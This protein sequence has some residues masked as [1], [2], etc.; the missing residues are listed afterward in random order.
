MLKI[1]EI[2]TIKPTAEVNLLSEL[3]KTLILLSGVAL[4]S[5]NITDL[6]LATKITKQPALL[7]DNSFLFNS[8]LLQL[9][10]ANMEELPKLSSLKDSEKEW[11]REVLEVFSV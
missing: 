6:K 10:E 8:K 2:D 7:R 11:L 4:S 9:E 1:P 5:L 3:A